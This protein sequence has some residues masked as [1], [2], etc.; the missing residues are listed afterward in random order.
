M[1][2]VND[3]SFLY[4]YIV[5]IHVCLTTTVVVAVYLSFFSQGSKLTPSRHPGDDKKS[6]RDD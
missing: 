6:T 1:L 4:M 5:Y 2:V 3:T